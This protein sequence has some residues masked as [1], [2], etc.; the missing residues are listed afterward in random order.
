MQIAIISWNVRQITASGAAK[1]AAR[2]IHTNPVVVMEVH[3]LGCKPLY[4]LTQEVNAAPV[5]NRQ[6]QKVIV[7]REIE[8]LAFGTL[9]RNDRC[10]GLAI[11]SL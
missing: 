7:L 5:A 9:N 11:N 3:D 10:A 4:E 1:R 8:I 6:V 2:N